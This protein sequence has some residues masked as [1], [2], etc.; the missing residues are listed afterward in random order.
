MDLRNN[1]SFART[2]V[3]R[4]P[5]AITI[6]PLSTTT[7][8]LEQC[9]SSCH[10]FPLREQWGF[11]VS[12]RNTII[13]GNIFIRVLPVSPFPLATPPGFHVTRIPK[14]NLVITV[15]RMCLIMMLN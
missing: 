15:M 10:R 12:T 6:F 14:G 8:S 2:S 4:A 7:L 5:T 1:N 3:Q 13:G 11:Y 9:T